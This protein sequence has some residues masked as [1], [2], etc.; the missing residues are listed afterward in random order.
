MK[1]TSYSQIR[2]ELQFIR[3]GNYE[4]DYEIHRLWDWVEKQM[5]ERHEGMAVLNI[6]PDFQRP[7]VW[8]ERQQRMWLE[9]ILRGGKTGRVFY[10]N[11]PSWMRG[12]NKGEFVLVDGKQRLEALRKWM[13]NEI[14][15]FGS[16]KSEYTDNPAMVGNTLKVNVNSLPTKADV[17]RWYLQMNGGGTPHKPSELKK[18]IDILKEETK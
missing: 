13:A 8:K 18:V 7:H 10:F 6:D 3:D 15:V 4:V 9:F 17:L 2:K 1:I 5:N 14:K 11:H 12:Y 16:Y